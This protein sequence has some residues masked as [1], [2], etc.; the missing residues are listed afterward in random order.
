VVKA[1][2]VYDEPSP[3]DGLRV[4]TMRL[5]PR[6]IAK[7]RVDVWLKDLGAELSNLRAHKA[8]AIDWPEMA[9]RYRAGLA[10]PAA[11]EALEALK[12][13]AREQTVTVMCGCEDEARCHR[14]ILKQILGAARAST[15][16]RRGPAA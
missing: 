2:R 10:E 4:L 8:G 14:G 15:P 1:K 5:W 9:R 16:A 6:G 12:A 13:L 11:A 3:A 7:A